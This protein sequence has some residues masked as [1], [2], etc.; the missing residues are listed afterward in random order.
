MVSIPK[1][2]SDRF[3]K[4]VPG[5]QK[6]LVQARDRDVNEADTVTIITDVLATVLGYDK[7]SEVT[8]EQAIRGT[9][10]DLAVQVEGAPKYLIEVKAIGLGLKENHL[11]QAVNYGANHGVPWVVLTNGIRWELYRIAFERP[12][13][14]ELVCAFDFDQ[15]RARAT[16]DQE[17][18]FLLCREGQ[19]RDAMGQFHQHTQMV[20][21][22]IVGAIVQSEAVTSVIRREIRRMSPDAKVTAEEVV[23]LLPDVLKR[24]VMEGEQAKEAARK[25]ARSAK[26]ALRKSTQTSGRPGS[27]SDQIETIDPDQ[28]PVT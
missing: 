2:V 28:E 4:S 19:V 8:S 18:L 23:A 12:I 11:R 13:S 24:D 16:E 9:Y 3:A 20:N 1:K 6:V 7:Y 26:L 10:C 15:L 22:F 17:K 25:V 5:F 14:H 21:R 27:K